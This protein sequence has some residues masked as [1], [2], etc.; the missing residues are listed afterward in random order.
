MLKNTRSAIKD[1]LKKE[2]FLPTPLSI[3]INPFYIIRRGLCKSI[4][5]F[6][7][8]FS[9]DILDFGCG[10]KPYESLFKNAKNYVGV[11][12]KISGHNHRDSKVDFF[13]DGF[14]L[15]FDDNKFDGVVC[16]EVIEHI[17]N[18]DEVLIEIYRV[19]RPGGLLLL[20]IPFAWDEHEAPF[21]FARYTSYGIKFI[22]EK[23]GFK[24]VEHVKTS[25]YVLAVF[26]MLIAYLSQ[27]VLP[28]R[29]IFRI[30]TLLCVVFPLNVMSLIF[31]AL[32][33]K[34]YEFFCN[35]IVLAEK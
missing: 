9:G 16:F 20:S 12:I 19:I 31:N 15:P 32:L 3:V 23:N 4:S 7:L 21:D 1:R 27:Y 26:Q 22:L 25:T 11:D 6:S 5:K 33:P 29:G 35:N 8:K 24:V 13:Y 28:K 10:S 17:F 14:K 34:R 2:S 18:V 30:L